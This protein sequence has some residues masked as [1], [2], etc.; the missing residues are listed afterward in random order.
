MCV[1]ST[2]SEYGRKKKRKGDAGRRRS[3]RNR[4][5][6]YD[7]MD[8]FVV[9]GSDSEESY[10]HRKSNK[11][12]RSRGYRD[13]SWDSEVTSDESY[14]NRK[15]A[16]KRRS[17]SNKKSKSKKKTKPKRYSDDS[18]VEFESKP[19]SRVSKIVSDEDEPIGG[20]RR[21]RGKI[22]N[23][24]AILDDSSESEGEK[25]KGTGKQIENCKDSSEEDYDAKEDTSEEDP[26]EFIEDDE[27]EDSKEKSDNS[28]E[29]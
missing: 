10:S 21:T 4:K 1:I 15:S 23:Y 20:P 29:R 18:D 8:D 24:N 16:T 22:T 5:V 19:K 28:D 14:S 7:D 17:T 9:S 27:E 26:D 6:L 25:V 2:D 13:D 12:S 11:K 3:S